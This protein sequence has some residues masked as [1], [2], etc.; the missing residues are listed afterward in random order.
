[1]NS[2]TGCPLCQKET[3]ENFAPFC[4]LFCQ[5]RD[6]LK[7]LKEDYR[8]PATTVPEEELQTASLQEDDVES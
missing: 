1:M 7:W 8:I 2:M 6:L 4:S 5:N 3:N